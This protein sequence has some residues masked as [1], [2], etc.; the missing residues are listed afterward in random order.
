M[1]RAKK[2]I[3]VVL[4]TSLVVG[5]VTGGL[6]YMR[7]QN[8]KTVKVCSVQN[9]LSTYYSSDEATLDAQIATSTTQS[10]SFPKDT[11]VDE[12]FVAKGDLVTVGQPLVS[13]YF[14]D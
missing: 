3:A 13:G 10:I 2:F 9:L 1:G 7:T 6:L 5:A 4:V 11:Y 14:I 12:V 8:V